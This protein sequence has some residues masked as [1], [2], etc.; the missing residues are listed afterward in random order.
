MESTIIPTGKADMKMRFV[1]N[2]VWPDGHSFAL[3][4]EE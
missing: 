2:S 3:A 1:T 4:V